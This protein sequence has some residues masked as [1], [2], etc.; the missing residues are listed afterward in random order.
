MKLQI[1]DFQLPITNCNFRF[2]TS[3]ASLFDPKNLG[4]A[5]R[6]RRVGASAGGG[7]AADAAGEEASAR[8]G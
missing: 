2:E 6:Y 4:F 7:S 5:V 3:H 1:E 8:G